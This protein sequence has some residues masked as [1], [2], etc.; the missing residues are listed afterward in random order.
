[1]LLPGELKIVQNI[2]K[3]PFF[4][5]L[6]ENVPTSVRSERNATWSVRIPL[7]DKIKQKKHSYFFKICP[8]CVFLHKIYT[9]KAIHSL[10]VLIKT[11]LYIIDTKDSHQ[12]LQEDNI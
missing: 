12:V 11:K 8:F 7:I 1:M 5:H 2:R 10:K 4:V 6:L 9:E 3:Y